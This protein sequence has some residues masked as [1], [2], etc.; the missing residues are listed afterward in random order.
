LTPPSSFD[1]KQINPFIESTL[2]LST[3]QKSAHLAGVWTTPTVSQPMHF[4]P[5]I[6]ITRSFK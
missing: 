3:E 5:S 1:P 4:L 6:P 2:Y